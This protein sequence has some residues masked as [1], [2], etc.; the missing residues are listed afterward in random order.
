VA[1]LSRIS[2]PSEA[3]STG[4]ALL[5][6]GFVSESRLRVFDG[7][8]DFTST[9][10]AYIS[11]DPRGIHMVLQIWKALTDLATRLRDVLLLSHVVDARSTWSRHGLRFEVLDRAAI[12][13]LPSL[14]ILDPNPR[15]S[16]D[17]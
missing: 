15:S 14:W 7:W 3:D 16:L 9:H 5:L 2:T 4:R 11:I 6:N 12:L 13:G 1:F 10:S 17:Q 8:T